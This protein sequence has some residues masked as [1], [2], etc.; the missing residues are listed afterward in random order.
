[1]S[2]RKKYTD[3]EKIAYYKAKAAAASRKGRTRTMSGR[4]AYKYTR[5]TQGVRGSGG[6]GLRK[7]FFS[8]PDV[9]KYLGAAGGAAIGNM[10][11]PGVGAAVGEQLGQ[12]GGSALGSLFRKITGWGDYTVKENSLLYPDEIVP[13]FGEDTIRVKK[14]EFI[15]A[16]NSTAS[17]FT[18]QSFP[19]NPGLDGTFPWLSS[20]ARNYEQYRINGM[21][22]QF[23]STSSDAIA[24]TT[25]LGLGQVILATDYNAADEEFQDAPQML[26]Y[27]FSNSAKPSDHIMHAIECAP[28]D[29]AQKLY[30]VRTGAIQE[31]QDPRL[32][33]LGLFQIAVNNMPATYEGMGQLWVSYDITFCKSQQNNQLGFA[34][35]TDQWVLTTGLTNADP[36]GAGTIEADQHIPLEGS[37][38]GM[39]M[40]SDSIFFPQGLVSGYYMINIDW[41]GNSTVVTSPTYTLINCL[42]V[43]CWSASTENVVRMPRTGSTTVILGNKFVV[44]LGTTNETTVCAIGCA[45]ATLPASLTVA[46]VVVTQVNGDLMNEYALGPASFAA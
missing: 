32:Y 16:I 41:F 13:S 43:E 11:A 17:V 15:A 14:R 24:S 4:G 19:I 9:G 12:Y 26:N 23:V 10:L 7:D 34:L 44:K 18:L 30:Y 20:I 42:P 37:S 33:D 29:T 31:G 38:I 28:T 45:I 40:D 8:A 25:A 3:K 46:N 2:S 27:M 39:T 36:F 22:F 1:M 21:I 6:Y 35:N 5:R